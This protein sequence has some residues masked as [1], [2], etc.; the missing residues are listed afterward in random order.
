MQQVDQGE[1]DLHIIIL[2]LIFLTRSRKAP[3]SRLSIHIFSGESGY[4]LVA[5][6]FS[7]GNY[8]KGHLHASYI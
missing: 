1:V 8:V 7:L 5:L 3:T 6:P 4:L 2:E